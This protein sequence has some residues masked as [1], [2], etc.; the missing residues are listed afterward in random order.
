MMDIQVKE[1]KLELEKKKWDEEQ[2]IRPAELVNEAK[3]AV[4]RIDEM[5]AHTA[6]ML[7]QA[8][9]TKQDPI[10][11]LLFASIE[12]AEKDKD[13]MLEAATS[14]G[15]RMDRQD[16][17]SQGGPAAGAGMGGMAPQPANP[18]SPRPPPMAGGAIPGGMA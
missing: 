4:A 5:K 17:K 10:I 16:D 13:R 9:A 2:K 6:E 1:G 7:A 8:G 11:K 18:T 3:Q 15:E 14:I 12:A